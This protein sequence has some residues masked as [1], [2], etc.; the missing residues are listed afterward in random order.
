MKFYNF[1]LPV[2]RYAR[3]LLPPLFEE[4]CIHFKPPA[5]E[6][7]MQGY[8]DDERTGTSVPSDEGRLRDLS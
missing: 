4:A 3:S 8:E 5:G 7:P 2:F 1:C 6:S